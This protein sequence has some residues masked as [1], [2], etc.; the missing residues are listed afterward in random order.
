MRLDT[1]FNIKLFLLNFRSY[2]ASFSLGG[3]TPKPPRYLCK[4]DIT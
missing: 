1:V 2:F 3:S 4:G